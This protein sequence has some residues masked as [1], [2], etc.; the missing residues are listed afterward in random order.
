MT[1]AQSTTLYVLN[2]YEGT[3][4]R[5]QLDSMIKVLDPLDQDAVDTGDTAV[6]RLIAS[7]WAAR[8]AA[9]EIETRPQPVPMAASYQGVDL[10]KH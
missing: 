4:L 8:E 2:T 10:V 9:S 5:Y 1:T 6:T 3:A 7:L